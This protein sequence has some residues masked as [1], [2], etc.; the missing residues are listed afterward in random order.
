MVTRVFHRDLELLFI[1]AVR[2]LFGYILS[3]T[4][5]KLLVGLPGGRSVTPF[6]E[7]LVR[8]HDELG[9]REWERLHFFFVDERMV[10]L[11]SPESNYHLVQSVFFEPALNEGFLTESQIHPFIYDQEKKDEGLS[12]Y[13]DAFNSLGGRFHI[14]ILGVG[15][16]GHIASLFPKHPSIRET[17]ERFVFTENSPKP[18]LRRITATRSMLSKA[19][20]GMA[21]F[22]GE[23]KMEAYQRFYNNDLTVEECPVKLLKDI[24]EMYLITN[25]PGKDE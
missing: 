9:R 20:C 1:R 4:E 17:V 5:S 14:V 23:G 25:L 24:D 6:L 15:E 13:N 10:S 12:D 2:T 22:V 8:L 3:S 21:I 16:D 18:P 11:Q 19:E 7:Q